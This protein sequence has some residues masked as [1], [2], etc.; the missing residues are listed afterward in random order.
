[1]RDLAFRMA[2][3][4]LLMAALL[5]PGPAAALEQCRALS[6]AS[7]LDALRLRLSELG[8]PG[9]D[10]SYLVGAANA[11]TAAIRPEHLNEK[12]MA[13]TVDS[14]RARILDCVRTTLPATLKTT[15]MAQDAMRPTPAGLP[16]WRKPR[17][18]VRELAFIGMFHACFA[19]ARQTFLR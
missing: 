13:C 16:G 14:V 15:P 4:S 19:S 17:H 7:A 3:L 8:Y 1:M 6:R 2:I 5:W 10:I 12:G 9:A 11:Q 18:T